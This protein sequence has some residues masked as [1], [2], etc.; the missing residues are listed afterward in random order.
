MKYVKHPLLKM[1]TYFIL[2]VNKGFLGFE[3]F[4]H[5]YGGGGYSLTLHY[6]LEYRCRPY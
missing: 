1:V 5:F 4:E 2:T 6:E 3:K